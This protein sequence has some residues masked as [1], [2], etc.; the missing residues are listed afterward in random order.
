M[1]EGTTHQLLPAGTIIRLKGDPGRQGVLTGK[2]R[3]QA[4]ILKYQIAFPEGRTFQPE[5]ELE[6]VQD[7]GSDWYNLISEGRF[8]RVR[9]LRRNLTHIHLSGRLA[10]LVYSMDATNTD[11]YAYQYK[12]V[13][14]FL[15]SP[16][17]GLLIADEVGLGK[18]IEAGLIWTELRARFDARRLMVVCPAMLREKWCSELA[19]RFGV[20]AEIMG[21]TEVLK[22]LQ[23]D[24]YRVPDGKGIVCSLQGL[25]PPKDWRSIES[26]HGAGA[27]LARFLD[28]RSDEE[29]LIDLVIID[30]AHYLR[31]PGSQNAVLGGL[32]RG[33]AENL[34]LLSAT[35]VNLSNDDL[36]YLLKLVDPDSFN[37]KEVFP[38]VITANEHL[39]KARDLIL[40]VRTDVAQ[41]QGEL[42]LAKEHP[43]LRKSR[44]LEE[45][46]SS[47]HLVEYLSSKAG[48]VRL[49]NRV[50]K[51]NLLRHALTRTRKSEV[52][53][54]RV[55]REPHT[56]F[57]PLDNGGVEWSFYQRVTEVI[58]RYAWE[59]DISD[60]FLLAGPQ[61]QVSSCMYAA[62][63]AWKERYESYE[64]Q[65]YEDFGYENGDVDISPLIGRIRS[66]VLPLIDLEA[67][68]EKDSKYEM[69]RNTV[70]DYLSARPGEKLIVFSFYRGTLSYLA[71]RLQGDG[72]NSLVLVGG[73]KESKQEV[74]SR[75]KKSS[76]I[77]VL[78]SSEVASEGVDLQF[79]RVLF[80]YDL[81][82]NPMKVE[83]RI[84]RIDRIGQ[85]AEKISII[86]L[87]FA[88][89]I[90]HRIYSRL[91]ARL[92][93]FERA[94]GGM[95]AILGEQISSL[96]TDL[97][98]RPLTPEQEQQ[99]IEQTAMAI[100]RIRHDQEELEKQA[101]H[102]IA[103][104]GYI[105]DEVQA[106][107]QF[108]KRITEEDLVA[109]VKDYLE[110]FCQG[111]DFN[112]ISVNEQCFN[113]RLPAKVAASLGEFIK[114]HKLHGQTHLATGEMISCKFANKVRDP[115]IRDEM[116]SQFHPLIR[117]IGQ[118][119]RDKNESFY[120]LVAVR[121]AKSADISS[122][123][124][125]FVVHKW[126]FS[127]IKVEEELPVRVVNMT[128]GKVLGR[129][130]SWSLL[131]LA[132]VEGSDWLEVMNC[133]DIDSFA[134]AIDQC[135]K[136]L[137]G[138]YIFETAQRRNENEDRVS[139]QIESAERHKDRQL[140]TRYELLERYRAESNTRLVPM[141]EGQIRK[142]KE[143]FEVQREKLQRKSELRT[144][145]TEVCFGVI[146]A[147]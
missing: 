90:D 57:V 16:S 101:S 83:Q 41:I 113:L 146:W 99:R 80:N 24:R 142:I 30:E 76:E 93:I 14:S 73:M 139:F 34:V 6:V 39:Q 52:T 109:Y 96:T 141:S 81:P 97:L 77:S 38:R 118:E 47:E 100:E 31:N 117:F 49:A 87:M 64:E 20:D 65:L 74:I 134:N 68:R 79:C 86:N 133:L 72:I 92:R 28:E 61:R 1:S 78:L 136:A 37:V 82:W 32:L 35:P 138:D 5:Y 137:D 55:V 63:K 13:I 84:G 69:F 135:E 27:K 108:K 71:E 129:D 130:E 126:E 46:V 128:T 107:H 103:H 56:C 66:D 116:I 44:Q 67:L 59:S 120:P 51:V 122:G 127:G 75:F 54:W 23:Q 145:Q 9:D 43:L 94:L 40:D 60:G 45:L 123:T 42:F 114:K 144:S 105:L 89:T 98:C 143:R 106:A 125:A 53:E 8:G 29:P 85:R 115:A 17:Q 104:G 11:F 22:Y 26:S 62:A 70:G 119:L 140:N 25:R 111:F 18:T 124:Y 15:D 50:E 7:D 2:Y 3:S 48:R 88:D 36:F 147:S 95:E 4:G 58:R 110:K 121:L 91:Y 132:R 21:S 112:Q 10:N 131:N 102:L 33:V 12:P 19:S